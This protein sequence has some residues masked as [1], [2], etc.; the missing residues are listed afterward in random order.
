MSV[1][2]VLRTIGKRL[3][4]RRIGLRTPPA[5]VTDDRGEAIEVRPFAGDRDALARMYE[6]LDAT[7]RAQ[8]VP[9]REA[10]AIRTWLEDLL[11]GTDVVARHDGRI[12][13]HVSLVP[14]GTGR[15]ELSIFVQDEYQNRG[16]GTALLSAGLGQARI[17]GVDDVWLSVKTSDRRLQRFYSRAGFS[18]VNPMG[19]TYRMSR[20]L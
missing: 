6:R 15:H 18:V 12:V 19:I 11:D 17:D 5:T 14:D 3:R 13:G 1:R 16:I 20:T 2:D 7:S 9:P 4:P 8:G 10:A